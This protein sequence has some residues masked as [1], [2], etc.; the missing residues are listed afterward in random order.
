MKC[1]QHTENCRHVLIGHNELRQHAGL[2]RKKLFWF[3]GFKL[4]W[5]YKGGLGVNDCL[6]NSF[7]HS[8]LTNYPQLMWSELQFDSLLPPPLHYSGV[9]AVVNRPLWM[10]FAIHRSLGHCAVIQYVNADQDMMFYTCIFQ[11]YLPL[12]SLYVCSSAFF[13][14]QLKE[15]RLW[16]RA[17]VQTRYHQRIRD[18]RCA[19]RSREP[20]KISGG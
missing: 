10:Y 11:C 3:S 8:G 14:D 9:R 2:K 19:C 1:M 13:T 18:F 12:L 4:I 17:V 15:M 7:L 20:D 5:S 6:F 16:R